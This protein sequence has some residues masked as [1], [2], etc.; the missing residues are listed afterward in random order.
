MNLESGMSAAAAL[1]RLT[2]HGSALDAADR[3][4]LVTFRPLDPSNR[5]AP[6]KRYVGREP[7][8]LTR[9]LALS[10]APAASV[11]SGAPRGL[12][13]GPGMGSGSRGCCS[14]RTG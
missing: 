14:S 6:F 4:L 7:V 9:D 10:S 3:E 2:R 13:R 12:S 5:P 8:P 11:L 1:H